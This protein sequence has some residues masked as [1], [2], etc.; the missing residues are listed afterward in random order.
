MQ[1]EHL[2]IDK[3]YLKYRPYLMITDIAGQ[4]LQ[5][6]F[7]H[8]KMDYS[9]YFDIATPGGDIIIAG[10]RMTYGVNMLANIHT[11]KLPD[12]AA[13]VPLDFR[14]EANKVTINTLMEEVKPYIFTDVT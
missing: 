10:R 4:N 7:K 8:N 6:T 14:G 13:I 1:L 12:G 2:Q 9:I 5:F 3:E 11:E